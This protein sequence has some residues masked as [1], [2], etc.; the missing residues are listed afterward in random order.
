MQKRWVVKETG[1]EEVVMDLSRQL[2]I[3]PILA[4]LLVQRGIEDLESAKY[5]FRP[6]LTHLH[7]PFLMKDMDKAV[8]RL[9]NAVIN[10]EK[11]LVFG[12]YDVD[13]TT[14]VALVFSFLKSF[15]E[16]VAF[17]I[18]DRY[19]EGYGISFKGIDYA[20]EH[21]YTLVISLDCGIKAN[22][23]IEYANLRGIDFIICDHHR[24]GEILPD[25]YAILD[26]KRIDCNYPYDELSGCGVGFKLVQGFAQKND[27][28]FSELH[29]YLDLV[30]VSIAADIVPLTG[31]NRTLAYFGLQRLNK[32][33]RPGFKAIM[34]LANVKKD[35]TISDIVFVI[36]PRINA[37][38]RI[39]NGG[40]AVEL[41]ISHTKEIAT[42]AG[43]NIN[44]TNIE[45]KTLDHSITEH[46]L[47]IMS[48]LYASK[49][50]RST[51]IYHPEWHKGVI[52]IVASRLT[53][54]YYRPT[55][56]LT[57]SNGLA[58]GSAR[59]V[60]DFDIYNAIEACS[61][62]LEQFGGHKFAAGLTLKPEN[63]P[64]FQQRFEDIVAATI[65][66]YMLTPEIEIDAVISLK[67]ITPSFYSIIKQ[68]APFGP[69]NMAP[70][71]KSEAVSD[72]GYS[73]VVGL[74]HLK[75]S[76][77]QGTNKNTCFDAIAFQRGEFQSYV[78]KGLPFDVCYSIE[79]N[80]W[81]GKITLQLNVKEIAI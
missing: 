7:D 28:P 3:N 18:P 32:L 8:E 26:P 10:K 25:A 1:K 38:G 81:N 54:K 69:G 51:V 5:F 36:G 41:L 60:K 27:I 45:R 11:I 30:A 22:D 59:S 39:E 37:A 61:D 78:A 16:P 80:E 29:Q 65:E 62:L 9:S 75:L 23:K 4:N 64:A 67:D 66:E 73:K 76:L 74:N 46:A 49:E 56:V 70:V 68:M 13:G 55:I 52:G 15:Y 19:S 2:N 6:E 71:F 48:D 42:L 50:L 47:Q 34:E 57:Q 77:I 79:E 72:T 43:F 12:D 44:I 35:L 14:S 58:T 17:Y 53:E 63:V 20:V 21:N 24:P 40:K 33:P 31:E